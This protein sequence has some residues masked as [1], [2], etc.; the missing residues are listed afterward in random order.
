V[1]PPRESVS[2]S[3]PWL[4]HP[5]TSG[6][7][8]VLNSRWPLPERAAACRHGQRGAVAQ[9]SGK[10]QGATAGR[11]GA[12]F[13]GFGEKDD[14]STG[15]AVDWGAVCAPVR[16]ALCAMAKGHC[17]MALQK[18]AKHGKKLREATGA[19][20]AAG[21]EIAILAPLVPAYI[22][23]ARRYFAT[24]VFVF[25]LACVIVASASHVG[26][27]IDRA[28]QQRDQAARA[29]K[30]AEG[31]KR[32]LSAML[33]EARTAATAACAKRTKA[34]L[35]GRNPHKVGEALMRKRIIALIFTRK[36][37]I[38]N[39]RHAVIDWRPRGSTSGP[40]S[41]RTRAGAGAA[42]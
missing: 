20:L 26:G 40:L 1:R 18:V 4:H 35:G 24:I 32:E 29:S 39:H 36:I 25:A 3:H 7:T 27:A 23:G 6:L 16:D 2:E 42:C 14:A 28:Q 12:A 37:K 38:A 15:V 10:I 41:F 19:Q 33:A 9:T 11:F 34:L 30:L 31:S 8:Q 17:V 21:V 13:E 22:E 5:V